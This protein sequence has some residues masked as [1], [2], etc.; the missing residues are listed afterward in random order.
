MYIFQTQ[1][2]LTKLLSKST[3]TLIA[4]VRWCEKFQ[5]KSN[6]AGRLVRKD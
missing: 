1:S 6:M 4:L 3:F 5:A 2:E